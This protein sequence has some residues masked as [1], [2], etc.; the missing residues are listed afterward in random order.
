MCHEDDEKEALGKAMRNVYTANGLDC[1]IS[2][3]TFK[4]Q[5]LIFVYIEWNA[6]FYIYDAE[7]VSF[8]A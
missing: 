1:K 4:V 3:K 6:N 8:L 5:Y 2:C 7:N